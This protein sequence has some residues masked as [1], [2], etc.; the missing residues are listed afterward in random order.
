MPEQDQ[1]DND[2]D[3]NSEQPEKD[4]HGEV[5]CHRSQETFM[6]MRNMEITCAVRSRDASRQWSEKSENYLKYLRY[7]FDKARESGMLRHRV[8]GFGSRHRV[9]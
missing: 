2:R 3:G 9:G 4:R 7:V 6:F 1:Q 5:S 8:T